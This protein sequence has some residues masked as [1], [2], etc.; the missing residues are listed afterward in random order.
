MWLLE[1][2]LLNDTISRIFFALFLF[3]Q[4]EETVLHVSC[5]TVRIQIVRLLI[6]NNAK[7]NAKTKVRVC[8]CL[9]TFHFQSFFFYLYYIFRDLQQFWFCSWFFSHFL[10]LSHFSKKLKRKKNPDHHSFDLHHND[11]LAGIDIKMNE[12]CSTDEKLMFPRRLI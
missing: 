5:R 12:L 2:L 11:C 7:V 1:F 4:R 8:C 10:A 9:N 3:K 6:R